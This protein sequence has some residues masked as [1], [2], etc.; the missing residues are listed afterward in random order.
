[1]EPPRVEPP[2]PPASPFNPTPQP[3]IPRGG[4]GCPKPLIIGCLAV[5]VVGGLALLGGFW[6]I[7][8]NL[9]RLLAF[10]LSQTES[11]VTA[12]LPQDV[13]PQEKERL[14]S[15]FESARRRIAAAGSS[16]EIAQ[17]AQQ[18][19]MELL[20]VTRKGAGLTRDDVLRLTE[21]LESFA[22]GGSGP[23]PAQP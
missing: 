22:S 4:A 19:N 3:A 2:P 18:L 11:T 10:T 6:W 1:M 16:Q 9:D 21:T 7:G 8:S 14:R 20:S 12:Q 5:L 23:P 15:A 13:T 17:E